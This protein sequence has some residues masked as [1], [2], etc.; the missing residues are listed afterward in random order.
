M[1]SF[2][3]IEGETNKMQNVRVDCVNLKLPYLVNTIKKRNVV[4]FLTE[5]T[6]CQMLWDSHPIIRPSLGSK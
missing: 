2:Q 3:A 1:L 5:R 6:L 4:H